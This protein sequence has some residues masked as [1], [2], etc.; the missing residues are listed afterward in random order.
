MST[1]AH[2]SPRRRSLRERPAPRRS[3]RDRPAKAPLSEEAVIAAGLAIL[4]EE[5]MDALTMRRLARA[6]DTGAASLYAYVANRDDLLR[7]LFDEVAGTIVL[8][9]PD[10]ARWRDQLRDLARGALDAMEAHPGIA[11]VAFAEVPTG[12]NVMAVSENMLGILLAGGVDP[13]R[14]AWAIDALSLI[15]TANAV[16]TVIWQERE[17]AGEPD[18][19]DH[20]TLIG[21]FAS[22]PADRFPNLV[23]HASVLVSGDE[24]DRFAFQIDTFIDGLVR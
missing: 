21:A 4:R 10:P 16:E 15:I 24:R 7:L 19:Y 5:G 20:D 13:Q 22:L 23:E 1:D 8:E 11:R 12:P 2:R 3:T 14:A 17:A 18:A 6:L 9:P